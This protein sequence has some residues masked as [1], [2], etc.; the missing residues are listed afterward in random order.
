MSSC[1]V[2]WSKPN[3]LNTGR[4]GAVLCSD[5]ARTRVHPRR[6]GALIGRTVR[7]RK[8]PTSSPAGR[9]QTRA[10]YRSGPDQRLR[11]DRSPPSGAGRWPG[12]WEVGSPAHHSG[13]REGEHFIDPCQQHGPQDPSR[14][15]RALLLFCFDGHW[16]SGPFTEP[17]IGRPARAVTPARRGAFGANTP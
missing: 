12:R 9:T 15:A 4:R 14:G 7:R 10:G 2:S 17:S 3:C 13:A 5:V 11:M 16:V 6:P 8:V 1:A